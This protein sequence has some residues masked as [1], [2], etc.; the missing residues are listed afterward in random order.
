MTRR[1]MGV[2]LRTS[3]LPTL[4]ETWSIMAIPELSMK[5]RPPRS[6]TIRSGF[7]VQDLVDGL[8]HRFDAGQIEFAGNGQ[9][10]DSGRIP[11]PVDRGRSAVPYRFH[12]SPKMAISSSEPSGVRSAT[13]SERIRSSERSLRDH[14][15]P[16]LVEPDVE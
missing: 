13:T 5:V 15:T 10:E 2:T 8:V 12:R 9:R 6:N 7:P 4:F 3:M 11:M 1:T 14:R 16:E